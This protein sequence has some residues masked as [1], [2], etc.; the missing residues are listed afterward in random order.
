MND[1]RVLSQN[2]NLCYVWTDDVWEEQKMYNLFIIIIE[3]L[4]NHTEWKLIESE[5]KFLV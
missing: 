5:E 1:V 2:E 3:Q 4:L